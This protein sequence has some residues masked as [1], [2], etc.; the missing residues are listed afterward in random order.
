MKLSLTHSEKLKQ[1]IAPLIFLFCVL[2]FTKPSFAQYP[3]N[4]NV[5]VRQPV[6]PYLLEFAGE[7]DR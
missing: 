1:I 6:S 5:N 2:G 4:I 7:R 3:V